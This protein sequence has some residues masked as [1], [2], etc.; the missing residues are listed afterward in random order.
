[1]D[2]LKRMGHSVITFVLR[3]REGVHKNKDLFMQTE[4]GVMSVQTFAYI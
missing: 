2:L 1:M 4:G 3:G